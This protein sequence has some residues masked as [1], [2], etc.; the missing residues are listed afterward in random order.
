MTDP[1]FN[2]IGFMVERANRVRR[3]VG[4][5]VAASWNLGV[6]QNADAAIRQEKIDLV[7]LGRPALANPHWPV[8]AARELGHPAP[9]SLVPED[10][11]WWLENFR[12]HSPSI[13]WPEPGGPAAATEAELQ[14]IV[15]R[16]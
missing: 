6:P 15:A 4:I 8:W 3:E 7:L 2:N 1:P 13:G 10:W 5:P 11:S 16:G 9:W 14:E 12:G